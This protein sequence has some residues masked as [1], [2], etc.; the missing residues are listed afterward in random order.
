[1]MKVFFSST[2]Q[3]SPRTFN[4]LITPIPQ[5]RRH[6]RMSI[7]QKAEEAHYCV[8]GD[9]NGLKRIPLDRSLVE[10]EEGLDGG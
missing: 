6:T 2:S 3:P 10:F 1:M 5:L 8:N 4:F 9:R 7:D